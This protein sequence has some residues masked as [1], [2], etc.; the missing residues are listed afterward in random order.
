MRQRDRE[1]ISKRQGAV[2]SK[3]RH[4]PPGKHVQ[5]RSREVR[6]VHTLTRAKGFSPADLSKFAL[7]FYN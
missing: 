2:N 4:S 5:N 6:T 7:P 1:R 3:P